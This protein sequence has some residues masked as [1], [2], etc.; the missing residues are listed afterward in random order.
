M[1]EDI[2][3]IEKLVKAYHR[4]VRGGIESSSGASNLDIID[5]VNELVDHVNKL[6][7]KP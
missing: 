4:Q 7:E 5:K 2:V 1:P 3:K 6:R